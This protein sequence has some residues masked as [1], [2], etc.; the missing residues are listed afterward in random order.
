MILRANRVSTCK[1]ALTLTGRKP[2]RTP[3]TAVHIPKAIRWRTPLQ[4]LRAYRD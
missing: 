2:I 3:E 4:P 1:K